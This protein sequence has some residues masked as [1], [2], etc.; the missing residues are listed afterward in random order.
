MTVK[1]SKYR[2]QFNLD[3]NT[4]FLQLNGREVFLRN[5][6]YLLLEFLMKNFG[7][8]VSRTEILEEVWD[9]NIFCN[10]N[11]VDVHVSKLRKKLVSFFK[12]SPIRTV[13][14]V[15]YIFE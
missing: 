8:I 2:S 3:P 14:S 11:T 13:H 5:K 1:S 9:R 12:F 6:E 7:K 4:R 10:T 15:G